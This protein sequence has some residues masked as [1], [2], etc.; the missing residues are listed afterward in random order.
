M[1]KTVLMTFLLLT[2][3]GSR[4][5]SQG[6]SV[7]D[8]FYAYVP[9]IRV[10]ILR[11]EDPA[12]TCQGQSIPLECEVASMTGVP[13]PSELSM[14]MDP[15]GSLYYTSQTSGDILDTGGS[16]IGID[17]RYVMRERSDGSPERIAVLMRQICADPCPIQSPP[18]F[19]YKSPVYDVTNGRIVIEVHAETFTSGGTRIADKVGLIAISGL[20]TM[21]DTLLTFTPGQL[22]ALMPAH[23]DGFP[24]ADTLQVWTGDVRSMPD[25][26]QA[27][28]L[29]CAAAMSPVPGQI[30]PVSD[31]VPDPAVGSGRYYL[32]SSVN[33]H[34]RR[35]G[36]QYVNG[37]FSARDSSTLPLCQ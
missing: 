15:A 31:T 20:P 11:Q 9:G 34:D 19:S 28:P 23:P 17:G 24:S 8:G 29:S 36:R 13:I 30:V 12:S 32:A 26:S 37:A 33:G 5:Y 35:L 25:W 16:R 3:C 18:T 4:I 2:V 10:E 27:Q 14:G 7:A 1:R 6:A 22:S 21:F